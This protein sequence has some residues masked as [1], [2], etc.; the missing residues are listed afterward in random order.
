VR[1]VLFLFWFAVFVWSLVYDAAMDTFGDYFSKFTNWTLVLQLVYLGLGT[2]ITGL[3]VFG[4]QKLKPVV[5]EAWALMLPTVT[6]STF[7]VS[8]YLFVM[9]AE[10]DF[11]VIWFFK[12]G[13]NFAAVTLVD[14]VLS[15]ETTQWKITAEETATILFLLGTG[16]VAQRKKRRALFLNPL[17][18]VTSYLLFN[19]CYTLFVYVIPGG[20]NGD[21][22]PYVYE[23]LDWRK[24]SIFLAFGYAVALCS[25]VIFLS[26]VFPLLIQKI[27][28]G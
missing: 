16:G 22:D 21:G 27:L 3:A 2:V 19:L 13:V 23:Q 6:I 20:T 15:K 17:C 18:Y 12:H 26:F 25:L 5:A 28:C 4:K 11:R 1:L 24:Q 7:V 8:F 14:L 9:M 10:G